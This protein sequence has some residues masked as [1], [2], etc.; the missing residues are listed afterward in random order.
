MSICGDR[1]ARFVRR[2]RADPRIAI[3]FLGITGS[4]GPCAEPLI[5]DL[6]LA[7]STGLPAPSLADFGSS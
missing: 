4:P 2:R 1:R 3:A 7:G 5:V 6:I